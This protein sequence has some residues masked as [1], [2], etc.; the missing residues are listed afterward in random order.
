MAHHDAGKNESVGEVCRRIRAQ[1]SNLVETHPELR[2]FVNAV[3]AD[4]RISERFLTPY[5]DSAV[6]HSRK[7]M[8]LSC[9]Q[10]SGPRGGT[11]RQPFTSPTSFSLDLMAVTLA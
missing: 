1:L 7:S 2:D 10:R 8:V 5:F 9:G 11:R 4:R 3:P 6:H